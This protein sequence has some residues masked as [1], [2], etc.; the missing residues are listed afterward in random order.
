MHKVELY[1]GDLVR[2]TP[3]QAIQRTRSRPYYSTL[4][5]DGAKIA[6]LGPECGEEGIIGAEKNENGA[7]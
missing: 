1:P 4:C 7:D 6:R 3:I 2:K 5:V